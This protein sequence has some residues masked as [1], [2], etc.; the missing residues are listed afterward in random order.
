MNDKLGRRTLIRGI[1]AAATAGV[2]AGCSTDTREDGGDGDGGDGDGG[3]GE[4]TDSEMTDGEMTDGEMTD[5]ETTESG[6]GDVPAEVDDYLS[7]GNANL[8]EGEI[9][10]ETGTDNPTVMVGAG[11]G[12]AFDPPAIRVSSGTTVT[13]EW[14]GAGGNHNVVENDGEFDSGETVDEEG[15]TFEHTFEESGNFT[16]VCEPHE[17]AGMLGAV[18][19]E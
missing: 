14:T 11:E 15:H 1:G 16:Y 17:V 9:V 4:M 3:D 12:F 10:D 7:E 19:V 18:V 6:S 2:L 13:W 5:G 8:Y